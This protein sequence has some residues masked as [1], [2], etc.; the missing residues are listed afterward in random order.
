MVRH[1]LQRL[2]SIDG[3]KIGFDVILDLLECQPA[4]LQQGFRLIGEVG[5]LLLR[6][7]AGNAYE[8]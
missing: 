8:R 1:G 6:P 7:V 2:G 4:L 5:R 3:W